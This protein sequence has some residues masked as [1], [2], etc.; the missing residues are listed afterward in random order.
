M[1]LYLSEH[2][3]FCIPLVESFHFGVPVIARPAGGMPEVAADAALWTDAEPD[4]GMVAE[5]LALAVS[6]AELRDALAERGR[7][8]LDEFSR[9]RTEAK[10]RDAARR[11]PRG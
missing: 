1:A 5:L 4:L 9:E 11:R 2:E 6:D 8:R 7:A 10:L 3:G